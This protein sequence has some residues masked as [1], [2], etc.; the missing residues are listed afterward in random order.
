M[1]TSPIKLGQVYATRAGPLVTVTR[2]AGPL[3]E[4]PICTSHGRTHRLDGSASHLDP[5]ATDPDDLICLVSVSTSTST[6]NDP[7]WIPTQA[8]RAVATLGK[9]LEELGELSSITARCLIQGIDRRDPSSGQANYLAL[10]EEMADV[11]AQI[12][13]TRKEF[14][15][16]E[17]SIKARAKK[18]A[19]RQ[20]QW[21]EAL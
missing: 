15:L 4:W 2:L 17:P 9:L 21:L 14:E 8:P 7:P 20:A 10:E 5:P 6:F 18:K 3:D 1:I 16:D 12:R 13:C 11:I 19:A